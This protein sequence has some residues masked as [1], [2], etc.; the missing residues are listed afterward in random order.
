[1][2]STDPIDLLLD[3]DG[4]L[5]VT[6]DLQWSKGVS[7]VMQAVRVRIQTFR[8]EWF[9]DLNHGV[10][11]WQDLLGQKFSALKARAAFRPEIIATPGVV[12]LLKLETTF[13]GATRTLDIA[14]ETR[15]E[16]G[17]TADEVELTL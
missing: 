2:L 9:A 17:D 4:D 7:G 14:F 10:P 16:F 3:D 8:A 5:V 1:M 15:T 6:T 13:E 12:E 11:Y